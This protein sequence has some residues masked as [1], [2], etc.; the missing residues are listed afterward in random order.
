MHDDRVVVTLGVES[1][2]A[3][4]PA[5]IGWHPWFRKPD[6]LEFT[7]TAMYERDDVGVP[8]GALVEP[9]PGPW[10]DCFV[11]TGPVVLRYDR[12][13]ASLVRIE[14]DCDHWVVFDEPSDATCVEPQSGPP[15]R[16]QP[17][18][19]RRGPLHTP[20]SHDDHLL[21]TRVVPGARV[22]RNHRGPRRPGLG[23]PRCVTGW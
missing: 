1:T 11:N 21:V 23:G 16:V 22:S 12:P 2:G 3:D 15:D 6:G 20:H 8:T 4:F 17:H 19:S 5:E 14:S 13:I 10:D 7:P 18:P 9:T